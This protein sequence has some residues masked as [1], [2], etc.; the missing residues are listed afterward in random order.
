MA[1]ISARKNKKGTTYTAQI[2]IK[3]KGAIVYTESQT[4][5][6]KGLAEQ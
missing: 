2:R 4:F 1:T 5:E 3:R 6:K